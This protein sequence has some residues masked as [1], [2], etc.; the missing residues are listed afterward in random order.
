[1]NTR[2]QW[3]GVQRAVRIYVIDILLSKTQNTICFIDL[4]TLKSQRI[5][6]YTCLCAYCAVQCGI[7]IG[8]GDRRA[9]GIGDRSNATAIG[10]GDRRAI[11]IGDWIRAIGIGDRR[12]KGSMRTRDQ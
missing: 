6:V 3:C 7:V 4:L 10:I 9:I 12:R 2:V 5:I 1:M 11:G 8:I